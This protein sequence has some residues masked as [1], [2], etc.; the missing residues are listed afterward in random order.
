MRRRYRD[1]RQRQGAG[2]AKTSGC[3]LSW[4]EAA[5]AVCVTCNMPDKARSKATALPPATT[6]DQAKAWSCKQ[7]KE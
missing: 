4:E 3:Y 6:N 5:C 7:A 1:M 2:T